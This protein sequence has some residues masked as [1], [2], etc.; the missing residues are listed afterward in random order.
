MTVYIEKLAIER[1]IYYDEVEGLIVEWLDTTST[2]V[3]SLCAQKRSFKRGSPGN[4]K[5]LEEVALV[6]R[7]NDLKEEH[8]MFGGS[9]NKCFTTDANAKRQCSG[10]S[11]NSGVDPGVFPLTIPL[12]STIP[13]AL[14]AIGGGDGP[15]EI[16]VRLYMSSYMR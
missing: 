13:V 4:Y 15:L 12:L 7:P 6:V 8:G 2:L 11:S 3:L 10:S 9:V 5:A 14:N 1:R 16:G